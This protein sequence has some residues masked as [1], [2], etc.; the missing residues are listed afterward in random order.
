MV[1]PPY[2]HA[3]LL[4][5]ACVLF[6]WTQWTS[7]LFLQNQAAQSDYLCNMLHVL[8]CVRVSHF[9]FI[10]TW[11]IY[12]NIEVSIKV[13]N[14]HCTS[15]RAS[16]SYFFINLLTIVFELADVL[17]STN[18]LH[19]LPKCSQPGFYVICICCQYQ[20]DYLTYCMPTSIILSSCM[21]CIIRLANQ[22]LIINLHSKNS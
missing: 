7:E 16:L 21:Y 8:R 11:P 18:P 15:L 10:H 6:Y 2:V 3:F 4:F 14:T 13:Q 17:A 9:R 12:L 20:I 1:R 19:S 22:L 5:T